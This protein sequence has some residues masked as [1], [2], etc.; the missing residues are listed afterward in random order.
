MATFLVSSHFEMITLLSLP[1]QQTEQV[2]I[3]PRMHP[4]DVFI[5]LNSKLQTNSQNQ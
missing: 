5:V 1:T 3:R 2:A 4:H